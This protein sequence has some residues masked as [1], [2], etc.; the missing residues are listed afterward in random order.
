MKRRSFL[1]CLLALPLVRRLPVAQKTLRLPRGKI[2]ELPPG[3]TV[4]WK[5]TTRDKDGIT[6]VLEQTDGRLISN[7]L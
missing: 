6:T 7:D 1:S 4:N 3:W 5:L 2:V